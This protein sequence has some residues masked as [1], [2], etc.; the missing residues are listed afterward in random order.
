MRMK[1]ELKQHV[2]SAVEQ[3]P[4][5]RIG[6]L[7]KLTLCAMLPIQWIILLPR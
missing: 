4:P 5:L 2:N 6:K 1:T 7:L 3:K